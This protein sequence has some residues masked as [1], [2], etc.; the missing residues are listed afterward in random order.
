MKKKHHILVT[1]PLNDEQVELGNKLGMSITVEPA[2]QIKYRRDW[3]PL[4][5]L[6]S[7]NRKIVL[8]FTSRSGVIA[9]QNYLQITGNEAHFEKMY[10]VGEK[11]A[12]A[13]TEI[14]YEPIIPN[15]HDGVGLA[16]K[17]TD[18][19]LSDPGLC[20]S[21]VVHLCGNRRRDEFRQFLEGSDIN[22]KDV[23]VYET[24]LNRMDLKQLQT[25]GILFYSP[26]AVQAFRNS[27]GFE[28]GLSAELFAIGRT[29]AEELSIE[30]G[31][32]VHISPESNTTT[33]LTF[34][35][36]ILKESKN[37]NE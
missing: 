18:D 21:I 8:A 22:V 3:Q 16:R 36:K 20:D 13:L 12:E 29:T 14:G 26:S 17:I 7:S 25:D 30:S 34:V 23:V 37:Q 5:D 24:I 6:V 31:K 27:G 33:F 10:A 9:F 2:I 11:T 1:R 15:Q 19:L 4:H 32:H 35:S 28:S